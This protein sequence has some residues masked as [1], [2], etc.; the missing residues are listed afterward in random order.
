MHGLKFRTMI[1]RV[2]RNLNVV[3]TSLILEMLNAYECHTY[4]E[5]GKNQND[6]LF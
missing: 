4:A 2:N 3:N 1:V 5:V 6:L